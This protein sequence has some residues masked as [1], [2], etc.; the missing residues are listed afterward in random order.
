[1]DERV[2]AIKLYS[3]GDVQYTCVQVMMY[4]YINNCASVE[5]HCRECMICG[6]WP[7]EC[8]CICLKVN[9][10]WVHTEHHLL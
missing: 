4:V 10:I 9:A 1:M 7:F 5:I 6:A 2:H 8:M 3:T